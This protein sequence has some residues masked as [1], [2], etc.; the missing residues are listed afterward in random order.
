MGK[1]D[2][3]K[4]RIGWDEMGKRDCEVMLVL[5]RGLFYFGMVSWILGFKF[6]NFLK[7]IFFEIF[8]NFIF[9]KN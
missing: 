9:L 6:F 8:E 7:K 4:D 3:E 1:S 2:W 5:L